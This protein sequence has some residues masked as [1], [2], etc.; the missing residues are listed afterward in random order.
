VTRPADDP[1]FFLLPAP[2][3]G[4]R[5]SGIRLDAEG[6]FS[7]GGE[8]F[9]HPNLVRAFH[10]WIGRHPTDGRYV[11][12]NGYDWVYLS[13][14]DAPFQVLGLR[15]EGEQLVAALSDGTEEPFDPARSWVG[16][17]EALYTNVKAASPGG[18]FVA[19]F[20]RQAQQALEPYLLEAEGRVAIRVG[21]RTVQL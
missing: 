6:N 11:L 1:R 8:P 2:D 21:N 7:Q 13:V 16:A 12:S 5:E 15:L 4:S 17:G 20:T 3:G 9:T 14:D 19:R 18:P 10:T